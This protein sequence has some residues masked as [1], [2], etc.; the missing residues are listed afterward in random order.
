MGRWRIGRI[1][2]RAAAELERF[3][4]SVYG[5]FFRHR[6]Y[7]MIGETELAEQDRNAL[8]EMGWGGKWVKAIDHYRERELDT[9]LQLLGE[10]PYASREYLAR[11]CA[12]GEGPRPCAANL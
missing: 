1:A 3:P 2:A 9:A 7:Q 4:K 12:C 10:E 6:Y 8:R 5:R 11:F